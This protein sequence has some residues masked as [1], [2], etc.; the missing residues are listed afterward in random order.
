[1]LASCAARL[2]ELRAA[3]PD[4]KLVWAD[5]GGGTGFNLLTMNQFLPLELFDAIYI[6]DLSASLCAVAQ[7]RVLTQG[8]H[9]VHV[10]CMDATKFVP[11]QAVTLCTFSYSLSMIPD[12][13]TMLDNAARFVSR[14]HGLFG[15]CDFYVSQKYDTWERQVS[16]PSR[17]F[18]RH[19]FEFSNVDLSPE[20]RAYAER[21]MNVLF[22][23]N[24]RNTVG[25]LRFI[26]VPFFVMV[27]SAKSVA[28]GVYAPKAVV[29]SATRPK[30]FWPHTYIYN[31]TW[32]DPREDHKILRFT[33]D[34][35]L[36]VIASAGCNVLDYALSDVGEIHAVDMNPA[37]TYLLELK[38]A[39]ARALD[40]DDFWLM[41]GMGY[42]RQFAQLLEQRLAPYLSQSAIEYW[43]ARCSVFR[44]P[45]S[46]FYS[47]GAGWFVWGLHQFWRLLGVRHTAHQLATCGDLEQQRALWR[48][49]IRPRSFNAVVRNFLTSGWLMWLTFGVPKAQM[50]LIVVDGDMTKYALDTLN[51]VVDYSDVT[52]DNY[53][54]HLVTRGHYSPQCCPRYLKRENFAALK[55]A[56][57]KI[58]V[59]CDLIENVLRT[60]SFTHAIMLDHLD[61][62]DENGIREELAVVHKH[63]T[64]DGIVIGRSAGHRPWYLPL[65]Q[66][67]GFET[68]L[69]SV[70][71]DDK[72]Y[73]DRVNMYASFYVAAKSR[74]RLHVADSYRVTTIEETR[75]T[76]ITA[77]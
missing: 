76:T 40:Y 22:E 30:E 33:P 71:D 27:G 51:G 6:V 65:Y 74:E 45:C 58:T 13:V 25:L 49:Q 5:I 52:N 31:F 2:R 69:V 61:W 37:Q 43:R 63:L 47:G 9:N 7:K 64:E 57:Q 23:Y 35:R 54:Y 16:W 41:F 42:H 55:K 38:I 17:V 4:V 48:Q 3:H 60:Q 46:F 15:I 70:R 39:A 24:G 56:T 20:R 8:W 67:A 18:W 68:A 73:I 44:K 19:W 10:M 62:R 32:E 29:P 75:P 77:V 36:I 12:F 28:P 72:P 59:H 1:M 50:D 21:H 14:E 66:E 26:N 53:F 34:S 11:P